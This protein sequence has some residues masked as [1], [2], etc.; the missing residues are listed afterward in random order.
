MARRAFD[1]IDLIE[2]YT[3]WHAGR[4]KVEV[5]RSLGV[6]PKTVRKYVAPAETAGIVPGGPP[7]TKDEWAARIR[8][9]FP[10]LVTP[11]LRSR[12]FAE[13]DRHH[14]AI[15]QGLK[16]NT[17]TTVWQ[18]L[19]DE[20]GLTASI[21][22][23][24][25]YLWLVFPDEV[26]RAHVTVLRDDPPPG[27]EAQVDYGFLGR[28]FDPVA[29]RLRRV[30]AFVLVL[31]HSRHMFVW[32]VLRMD[33]RAWVEAH[34]VAFEFLGGCPTRIVL[35]NLRAGVTRPDLYDPKLNRAYAEL[36]HH[37]GVILDP[38]RAGKPRDKA[39]CERQMPFVRDS[40]FAGRDFADLAAMRE[41]AATWCREVAGRRQHRS[42]D[43][44]AP[45]IV[46]E[47]VET[48]A[49][50]PLPG[51]PF[52]LAGWSC[53]KVGP[54][55]HAKVGRAFY[56]VPWRLIGRQ[57]DARE[58]DR[59]VEFFADGELVKTHVRI[60]RGRQTDWGDYPP[61]KV[62]FLMRTPA[63]CRKKAAEVGSGAAELVEGLLAVNALHRLR[64]AQAL[65]G[66]ADRHPPS[67]V[68]AACRLAISVGDPCYRTVKG[69]LAAG[70]EQVA[71]PP[72]EGGAGRTTAAHLHGPAQLFQESGEAAS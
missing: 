51:H 64:Q 7:L 30:W 53:P 40:F 55:T 72:A 28:W 52:E 32:P 27:E 38:A 59:T 48:Q 70:T 21:T 31:A 39:R 67:R 26:A 22:S 71:T 5:A 1:V 57:L 47:A 19:R 25:R 62:A 60:E 18:R 20:A 3:H 46:F 37:Y 13:I 36:G 65:L 34:V 29:Q 66:L 58:T 35:D 10:E 6:D 61:E 43:G 16:T 41:A 8:E 56:S 12:T 49:L 44:T 4:R 50:L 11:Q 24:R 23:F 2:I 45:L 14:G 17:A 33:Q 9:W 15:K 54:D 69:I 42:L 63:W 68:D